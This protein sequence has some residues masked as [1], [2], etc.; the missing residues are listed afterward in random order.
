MV[1]LYNSVV[2]I[3]VVLVYISGLWAVWATGKKS[4][5]CGSLVHKCCTY[6]CTCMCSGLYNILYIDV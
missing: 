3:T 1:V 5:V 2:P 6:N 4:G